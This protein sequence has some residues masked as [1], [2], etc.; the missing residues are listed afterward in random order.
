MIAETGIL[1]W[2]FLLIAPSNFNGKRVMT[3]M[4]LRGTCITFGT[5]SGKCEIVGR[6]QILYTV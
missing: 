5:E 1:F 4:C 6:I 3:V 2:V